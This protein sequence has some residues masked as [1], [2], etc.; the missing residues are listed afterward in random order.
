MGPPVA[1]LGALRWQHRP[2]S[3]GIDAVP[4]AG[5][6]SPSEFL[7]NPKDSARDRWHSL[8]PELLRQS[9]KRVAVMSLIFASLWTIALVMNNL[10]APLL[11]HSHMLNMHKAWPFPGNFISWIGLAISLTTF[12]LVGRIKSRPQVLL[13]VS[14]VSM[15]L[16][17]GL[18]ALLMNWYPAV[19]AWRVSWLCL[20]IVTYPSIV[21]TPP[22]KTLLISLVVASMDPFALWIAHLRGVT[23]HADTFTLIW[24]VLP[25]YISVGLAMIPSTM[26][27]GLGRQV[28]RA[29][30]LG[31]YQLGD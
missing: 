9:C 30:D 17:A 19:E 6:K 7:A 12:F 1:H 4:L 2:S 5:P 31:S 26:I 10:V 21:P 27:A 23:F 24:Y 18:V 13:N 25:N 14:H 3:W 8:P 16:G 11:G 20:I 15:I 22:I 29:R 28:N